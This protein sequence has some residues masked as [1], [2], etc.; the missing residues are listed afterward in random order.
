[1]IK[2]LTWRSKYAKIAY[3]TSKTVL[4]GLSLFSGAGGMD[5]G[6]IRAGIQI[7]GGNDLDKDACLTYEA[8]HSGTPVKCGDISEHLPELCQFEG[9]D[10]VFGGPPCQWF[11]VAG[12]MNPNDPRSQ[13]LWVFMKVVELTKPRAFVCENVKAL[14]VL[15]KWAEIRQRLFFYAKRLGYKYKLVVLNSSSFGVPQS[16][17]RMFLIGFRDV[18]DI[19]DLEDRFEPYKRQPLTIRDILLPLGIAGSEKNS[20]I[21]NAKVTIAANP[22]MRR[23]PYAGMMFNGQ[24]RPLNPAGYSCALHASMGGNKTP[25]IDEEHCYF[26][27]DSWV[28]WYHSYLV[29]GGEPLPLNSAPRTLRRLTIDEAL[30]IQTFPNDYQ[31]IGKPS[32]IY[33]QIGNAVPCD[34]AQVVAEVVCN[35]LTK[36]ETVTSQPH[37]KYEIKQLQLAM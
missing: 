25:I 11:S 23:S 28:E 14:A 10:I 33:R 30:R 21:C 26:D 32:S 15:D 13:M 27:Q 35:Y 7:V 8:N 29:Q 12:K 2:I 34:L 17:E 1:M 22:V 18:D 36:D 6:F 19:S 3:M 20:R 9:I 4:S 24:G 31:F 16:R 37:L 5:V